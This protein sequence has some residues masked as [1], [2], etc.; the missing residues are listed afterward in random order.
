MGEPSDGE[1]MARARSGDEDAFGAIVERHQ[2]AL[3]NYLSRL[4]GSREK[5]EEYAQEAFFRLYRA[6]GRFRP[7]GRVAPLLFRIAVNCVRS[8][9]RRAK[10]WR[11]LVPV[12]SRDAESSDDADPAVRGELRTRVQEALAR[13]PPRYREAV[14]LRDIEEWSYAEIAEALR[15]REGTLKSRIGRGR[16]MLRRALEG[17]WK[18]QPLQKEGNV[19]G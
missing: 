1:L 16:E 3:V 14:L 18:P 5:G 2:N 13:L 19:H 9:A 11:A 4:T 10:L 17:Y 7:D 12:L 15:C 8:D 6:A